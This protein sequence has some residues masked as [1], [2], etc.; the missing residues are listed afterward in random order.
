MKTLRKFLAKFAQNRSDG[1][2]RDTAGS[3]AMMTALGA[4]AFILA[5]GTAV[6]FARASRQRQILNAAVDSAALALATSKITDTAALKAMGEKYVKSNLA[7]ISSYDAGP[8]TLDINIYT[9]R[10]TINAVEKMPTTMMKIVDINNMDL[11]VYSEARR[12]TANAEVTLVLDNT[13][14]MAGTK[15]AALKT[16]ANQLND[17]LF[18]TDT[19]STHLKV[20]IVPFA[21]SVNVGKTYKTATWMDTTGKNAISK[22]NF[23]DTTK[24]GNW[25]YGQMSNTP[26]FG[27]VEQRKANTTTINYDVDDTVPNVATPDTLFPFYFAPDEATDSNSASSQT[28]WGTFSNDYLADWRSNES[29]SSNTKKNTTL[30]ARQR[31]YE[32]YVATT[33][34]GSGKGPSY[35]CGTAAVT[36]LTNVKKT[37]TDQ[38][39]AMVATGNT[40]LASGIGWGLRVLSPTAPFTEGAA[41]ND[42]KWHKVMIVMTDGENDWGDVSNM[43]KTLYGGYGYPTQSSSRLGI[44]SVTNTR[45]TLD[46]RTAKACAVAK[47]ASTNP[48]QPIVI[49]TITFGSIDTQAKNLMKACAS[50]VEKYFHA[51]DNN[52]LITAFKTIA[53]EISQVYL[54]K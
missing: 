14:S 21:A 30:D 24:Y 25:A 15:I 7:A 8:L 31:R 32:K 38:I 1:L 49:Y 47:A 6:D 54:S 43:N 4:T 52:T 3:I 9:D 19:T 17:I 41:Y 23:T 53:T 39:A 40:N 27:C 22:L 44:A 2:L 20:A 37:I 51:P 18:G 26:W 48:E 28:G 35:N 13:G 45:T 36:P 16:A 42:K 11:S 46:G 34:S 5:G 33:P 12:V 29:V 10:V 50:D